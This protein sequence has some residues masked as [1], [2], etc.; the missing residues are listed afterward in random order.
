MI[1]GFDDKVDLDTLM[2]AEVSKPYMVVVPAGLLENLVHTERL[3]NVT[4]LRQR[5]WIP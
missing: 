3:N 4:E 1:L 2:S 5:R